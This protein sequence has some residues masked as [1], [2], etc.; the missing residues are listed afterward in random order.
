MNHILAGFLISIVLPFVVG[1]VAIKVL[2]NPGLSRLAVDQ[3]NHRSLHVIPVPRTGG[4]AIMSAALLSWSVLGGAWLLP[5]AICALLLI[6]LS[7]VDDLSGLSA[8]WRFLG[9]F[10]VA[11]G[12]VCNVLPANAVWVIGLLTV[13][14]VWM[15]NL[16]NFMD[17]S[18]GL[19]GGMSV[20]GF[21]AYAVAGWI[22]GDAVLVLACVGI[23]AA[24]TAFLVYNFHPARIFMGDVGSIPLGFLAGA[25]GLLGWKQEVWPLWFPLLVFSPFIVDASVTLCKRAL[26]GEKIWQAHRNHYY[27]RLVQLGWGHRK[28]ALWGY[29]VMM[30]AGG[31]AVWM[32]GQSQVIQYMG[33]AGWLL[34]YLIMLLNIDRMWMNQA[35]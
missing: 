4:L 22:A 30:L 28:T 21:G 19:A 35:R 18:D 20:F 34:V 7:F 24:A 27:Q 9:Q 3:P 2:L 13:A 29:V 16:Y 11:G 8:G 5:F 12:F 25:I 33:L 23:V 26:R 17:G 15:T 1:V 32:L 31:S 10:L 14:L 6:A